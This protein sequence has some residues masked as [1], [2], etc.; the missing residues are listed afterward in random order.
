MGNG[1]IGL[2]VHA[3]NAIDCVVCLVC[4]G[5][6]VTAL[7]IEPLTLCTTPSPFMINREGQRQAHWS[8]KPPTTAFGG[9]VVLLSS[10]IVEPKPLEPT[11]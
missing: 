4:L 6:L 9:D 1:D 2:Q 10:L 5:R 8:M 3:S 7:S 11:P